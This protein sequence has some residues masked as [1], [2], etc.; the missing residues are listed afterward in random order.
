MNKI[1]IGFLSLIVALFSFATVYAQTTTGAIDGTV[2][3]ANAGTTVVAV[4]ESR[5][6]E[7]SVS[8]AGGDFQITNLVPGNY[9]VQVRNG[10]AVVDSIAVEVRVDTTVTV[11]LAASNALIEEILV[12]GQRI[13][14]LDAGIAESGIV[15]TAEEIEALPVGRSLNSV[16]LLSPGATGG[17]ASFGG[18]SFSGSSVAENQTYVN[19]L[20]ITNF[21]TGVGYG[22]VPFEFFGQMQTKTGAYGA[23]FGRSTG[24]VINAVTKSGSN[25]FRFGINSNSTSNQSTSPNTFWSANELDDYGT[26]ITDFWVS[27]PLW[28]DRVFFY[29][30]QQD[31]SYYSDYYD[32]PETGETAGRTTIDQ[33]FLGY[34]FDVYLTDNQRLEYT[35]WD[36]SS[37]T[38]GE[39]FDWDGTTRT[40]LGDPGISLSGGEN[41][42][43]AYEGNF[44]PLTVRYA[45]GENNENRTAPPVDA[46]VA[47]AFIYG[48]GSAANWTGFISGGSS[49][50]SD[51]R[52]V[53]RFD[54]TLD[55]GAHNLKAGF[56]EE[57]LTA[58][59]AYAYNGGGFFWRVLV[60]EIPPQTRSN[61]WCSNLET[62]YGAQ[63]NFSCDPAYPGSAIRVKYQAGG[64]FE[65]TNSAFYLSDTWNV[66]D[67]LTLEL[68]IRNDSFLNLN[69]NREPFADIENQWAPRLSAVYQLDNRTELFAN[70]GEYYLPVAANTNIRMSGAEIYYVDYYQINVPG[71]YDYEAPD[72]TNGENLVPEQ[73]RRFLFREGTGDGEVPDPRDIMDANIEPMYQQEFVLGAERVLDNGYVVGVKGLYRTLD[74]T[75]EDIL[76]EDGVLAYYEGTA[77]EAAI[78]A[79]YGFSPG[80][81]YILTNPGTDATFYVPTTDETITVTA[82]QFGI[83]KPTREWKALELTLSRPWDGRGSDFFSYTL[84]SSYGNYEGWVRSDNGQDDAGITSLFDSED[85]TANGEGYLPNDRRH[86]IKYYGNRQLT[87]SV[88]VGLNA[89]YQSGRPINCFGQQPGARTYTNSMFYCAGQIVERGTA[90]RTDAILTVDLNAQYTLRL[91][92]QEVVLTGTVYNLLD[93]ARSSEIYEDNTSTYRKITGYQSP[94]SV[95]FGFRYNFN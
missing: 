9:T 43:A 89:T 78:E 17:D 39:A 64:E 46:D 90:G 71:G 47:P 55:V 33:T 38:L 68:G 34:R 74:T 82:E 1:K 85:M 16:A 35:Y 53:Q 72:V 22:Y 41:W 77:N 45:V 42:I 8:A 84:G 59:D 6:I 30:M 95:R 24:G 80:S 63:Y 21:R 69:G 25:D 49:Y 10:N 70:Y 61:Y 94:R 87:D 93:S 51:K 62:N 56:E 26:D 37:T 91:G 88:L 83:P 48:E 19:G 57:V 27:G 81:H 2:A 5:N 66:N 36:S 52:E 28:R 54:V 23:E 3:G 14:Q 75:I 73:Y 60:D 86:T 50:G 18:V 4:D 92:N 58:I 44:G 67:S 7:R 12:S 65:N 20:P 79:V 40:S 15:V 29:A 11:A 13:D 31:Y 76:I 32:N